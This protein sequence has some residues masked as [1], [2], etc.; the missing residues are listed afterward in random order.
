MTQPARPSAA[1][2]SLVAAAAAAATA[3]V[4]AVA[5]VLPAD[6]AAASPADLHADQHRHRH[7]R[8][9]LHLGRR[10]L[11]GRAGHRDER[12]RRPRLRRSPGRRRHAP[13]LPAGAT[14]NDWTKVT[15]FGP[16]Q[17]S[18]S[19]TRPRS[20]TST[21]TA[22]TTS[23]CRRATSSA[24][25][26]PPP[27]HATGAITWWENKGAG[28]PFVKHVVIEGQAGSYHGVQLVDLDSDGIKDLLSV[29]EEAKEA[30]TRSTTSST[31][32]SSRAP[33]PAPSRD[34]SSSRTWRQP[35]RRPRHRRRRR[36]RHRLVAVLPRHDA[37]PRRLSF[38]WLENGDTDGILTASDFTPRTIA[39][40]SDLRGPRSGDGLP[41][42][43][44][45]R[46]PRAGHDVLDRHQPRQPLHDP[47]AVQP[48][49]GEV[50]EFL[51]APTSARSGSS[52]PCPTSERPR[53]RMPDGLPEA[54][55][56][57]YSDQITARWGYGRG[58]PASSG[59]ATSTATRTST[60]LVSGD[61]DRRLWWVENEGGRQ[62]HAAPADR[63]GR[64]LGQAGGDGGGRPEQN[65][66]NELVFSSFDQNT[67]AI[68]TARLDRA[69]AHRPRP[70]RPRPR[71]TNRLDRP[72]RV[73]GRP[74][75]THREGRQ[76]GDL[77]A[78]GSP[79]HEGRPAPHGQGRVRPGEGQDRRVGNVRLYPQRR[80]GVQTGSSATARRRRV[81]SWSRTPARR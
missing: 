45:P 27:S 25:T 58:T 59:T 31:C 26:P 66:T 6:A 70:R 35:A 33:A 65:G 71:P 15:V 62:H 69:D 9:Q 12:L 44:R 57:S 49:P 5:R 22:T 1:A 21:A 17:A 7:R 42:P 79:P 54:A 74:R 24:P 80:P 75:R 63:R 48:H 56:P 2:A 37:T 38:L 16:D 18:S 29:S 72:E 30:A 11:R 23:S 10:G 67:L 28:T 34:R 40:S 43:S 52:Q 73:A 47:G 60:C 76:E 20:R 53:R 51:P 78:S 36:P 41:D 68:W 77:G 46:L 19:P 13:A 32:S 61:G 55:T 39:S 64:V 50:I 81:G 14:L 8:R 4:P 3:A